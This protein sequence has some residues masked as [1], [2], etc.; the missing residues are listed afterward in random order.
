V[1]FNDT[2]HAS[3]AARFTTHPDAFVPR[4]IYGRR[5][6]S[7]AAVVAGTHQARAVAVLLVQR[8]RFHQALE[9]L[10]FVR[11]LVLPDFFF[12]VPNSP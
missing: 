8:S 9:M 11:Y 4:P 10:R 5:Q 7:D 1:P 6:D 12:A 2:S 3:G